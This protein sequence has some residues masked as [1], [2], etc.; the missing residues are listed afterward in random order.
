MAIQTFQREQDCFWV[1]AAQSAH[2]NPN[3]F[4]AGHDN[5]LI[6]FK[7]ERERPAFSVFQDIL[8]HVRDKYV[9]SYDFHI[10]KLH[11]ND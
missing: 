11:C 3:L 8:Y 2:P 10:V 6:N 1:L 5:G 7:L 9:R 4:A